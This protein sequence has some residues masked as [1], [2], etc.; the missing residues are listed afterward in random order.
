MFKIIKRTSVAASILTLATLILIAFSFLFFISCNK[1]DEIEGN[2]KR[3]QEFVTALSNYARGFNSNFIIIPQNGCELA[4][5]N[6]DPDDG[7]NSSYI[8][9]ID[10]IGIEELFYDEDGSRINDNERLNMLRKLKSSETIMVSDYVKNN[11]G[12]TKSVELNKN[13]G[14]LSFPRSSGNYEYMLVPK[15]VTDENSADINKLSDAKN[16]L[17]LINVNNFSNKKA[18]IDA[19]ADSKYDIALIDLFFIN[20]DHDEIL[21]KEDVNK[22]KTKPQG[23][24]RLVIAY[25]SVGS[26]ENYRYYWQSGWKVGKPKWLKKEYEDWEDEIWVQFWHDEWKSII[27]GN[28][29]SYIKKIIDAGFDGAYLDNVEAYYFLE[30]DD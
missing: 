19:I 18:M 4:F 20:E 11:D 30:E 27:Y 5:N 29:K 14:F 26:A 24:K 28:D 8:N 15:D 16:Y 13:E 12:I 9:A 10:G 2:A 22:L 7:I 21:T 17:Y 3:M 6:T 25:I 1:D 23:G